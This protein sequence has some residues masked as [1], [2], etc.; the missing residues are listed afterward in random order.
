MPLADA[1]F[2][3]AL[4]QADLTPEGVDHFIV[5]GVHPR[6]AKAFSARSGVRKEAFADDLT[7]TVGNTGSAALGLVLADVLD[8]AGADQTIVA[9]VLADGATAVVLRTT[10]ALPQHRAATPVA[11]QIASGD[12]SLSYAT[13]LSWKG[14]L[15]REPPRRPDPVPPFAPPAARVTAWKYG[16]VASR[17][18]ECGTRWLPPVRVCDQ[19]R[20]VDKMAPEPMADVTARIRTFSV[21]NLAYTP[22]PP[23]IG[24]VVDFDGGGRFSCALTDADATKVAVGDEVEMTFRRTITADGIHNYFWKARPVRA[25][26]TSGEEG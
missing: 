11:A 17:C 16:F 14:F 21:D 8:R 7:A 19:C 13:F 6:A 18:T 4:K 24:V 23:L 20:A 12:D 1:A 3:A 15:D 26:A 22:S 2:A 9:V 25:A 10:A 5:V